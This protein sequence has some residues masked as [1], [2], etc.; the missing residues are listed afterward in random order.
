MS[1]LIANDDGEYIRIIFKPYKNRELLKQLKY[2]WRIERK[3][4]NL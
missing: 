1:D 2:K 3:E 4:K